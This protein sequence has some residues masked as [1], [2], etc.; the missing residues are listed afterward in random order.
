MRIAFFTETFLPKVDGVVNTLCHLLNHL[1]ERGHEALV[2][3]PRGGPARFAQAEVVGLPWFPCPLYP[4]MRLA[5][6][7]ANISPR[8]KSFRPDFVH[9]INPVMLGLAGLWLGKR[10][11]LPIVASYH[12]DLPGFATRWGWGALSTT[13]WNYLRRLHNQANLNLCPSRYTQAELKAHGFK[14]VRVWGR[15]VD[16]ALFHPARRSAEWRSRLSGGRPEAPLLL[17]VG[18]LAREKRVRWLG[19]VIEALPGARL[20]IVGDGPERGNLEKLFASQAVNFL[21]YLRGQALAQ[22]Y[23]AADIFVFPAANETLGNVVLEAMASGL[24]VI[25]PAS[26]GVLDH[27][28]DGQTGRLFAP[29]AQPELIAHAQDLTMDPAT[30]RALGHGGRAHAEKNT[31]PMVFDR[32]LDDYQKVLRRAHPHRLARLS[33]SRTVTPIR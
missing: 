7:V 14:R 20:A 25:A 9:V 27:V 19:P 1:A 16:T 12:T 30:A 29:E 28:V 22:A 5:P 6:P 33:P 13:L 17:Y 24:P 8:L 15:G 2:F 26:G 4:E 32:L 18:R 10:L 31:W 21:G 3:A 11:R 23:A